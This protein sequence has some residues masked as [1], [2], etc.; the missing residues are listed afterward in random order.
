MMPLP[1][2]TSAHL[3]AWHTLSVAQALYTLSVETGTGLNQQEAARR[4]EQYGRN[5][6]PAPKRR[7]PWLRLALQFHNPLI[8]VLLVAGAITFGLDDYVDAGVIAG[9]VLINALIGFIQEGKAEKALEAVRA[10][11]ASHATVLREGERHEIDATLLAPGDIVLLESGARVPADLRL[12]RVKNLR[13]NEAA[14]TGESVPVDKDTVPV[15]DDGSARGCSAT[16]PAPA[17]ASCS[18]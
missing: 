2:S 6:L 12:L 18:R 9:V 3:P 17:R 8:Y 13:V 14:L 7:G 1:P 5:S 16:L 15:A 4:L 11:L 10:M